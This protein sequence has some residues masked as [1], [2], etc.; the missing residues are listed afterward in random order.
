MDDYQYQDE[1]TRILQE[2]AEVVFE[3]IKNYV[4]ESDVEGDYGLRYMWDT[5]MLQIDYLQNL[6]TVRRFQFM[7]GESS[8][9]SKAASNEVQGVDNG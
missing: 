6:L 2:Q 3:E 7:K 4:P 5:G 8:P 9:N 1:A